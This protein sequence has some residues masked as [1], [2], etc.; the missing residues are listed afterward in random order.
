MALTMGGSTFSD[1][2]TFEINIFYYSNYT[3]YDHYGEVNNTDDLM[4][5][6]PVKG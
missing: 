3:P 1:L 4:T 6:A 2:C 5:V